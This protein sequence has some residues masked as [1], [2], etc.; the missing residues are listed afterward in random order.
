MNVYNFVV[1]A[2]GSVVVGGYEPL[3]AGVSARAHI[4]N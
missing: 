1:V 3:R 4:A 2:I